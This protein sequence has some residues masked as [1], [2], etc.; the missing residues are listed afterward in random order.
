MKLFCPN[1]AAAGRGAQLH[2]LGQCNDLGHDCV[3]PCELCGPPTC[4][5]ASACP[6]GAKGKG[7]GKGGK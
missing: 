1:C 5:W 6:K 2:G 4:H 7:K 3:I